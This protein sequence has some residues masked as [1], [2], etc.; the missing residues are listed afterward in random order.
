MKKICIVPLGL[1]SIIF[2]VF[3]WIGFALG[4]MI[5]PAFFAWLFM[6]WSVAI[7]ITGIFL[8]NRI[9]SIIGLILAIIPIITI[10]FY[11]ILNIL[12]INIF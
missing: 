12:N 11:Y 6:Y 10:Y 9:T 1:L 2:A 3:E 8:E 4:F 5:I 7:G